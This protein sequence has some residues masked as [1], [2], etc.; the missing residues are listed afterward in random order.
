MGSRSRC[1]ISVDGKYA[2]EKEKNLSTKFFNAQ[3]I[4]DESKKLNEIICRNFFAALDRLKKDKV[5][6]GKATFTKRYGIN[7]QNFHKLENDMHRQI[8]QPSWLY[9]IIIDY[10]VNPMFLMTGEEPFYQP[11]WNAE[12]VKKLQIDC[13]QKTH[14]LQ[15]SISQTF[16]K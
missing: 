2:W 12:T 6:R 16:A 4:M 15:T 3:V 8:F 14:T 10:K 1:Q 13:K 5:I 7:R 9:H 11:N